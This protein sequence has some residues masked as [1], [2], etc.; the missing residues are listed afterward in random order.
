MYVIKTELARNQKKVVRK[1]Y[2]N[3]AEQ[4]V[5]NVVRNHPAKY[6]IRDLIRDRAEGILNGFNEFDWVKLSKDLNDPEV[7]DEMLSVWQLLA[8]DA[9]DKFRCVKTNEEAENYV[10]FYKRLVKI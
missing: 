9:L 3:M 1:E 6:V 4:A 10:K 5:E 2:L 7:K 8:D